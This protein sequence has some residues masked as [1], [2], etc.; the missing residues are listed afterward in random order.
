MNHRDPPPGCRPAGTSGS[1]GIRDEA[2]FR[3]S[4]R[5]MP[6]RSVSTRSF[7]NANRYDFRLRIDPQVWILSRLAANHSVD[8]RYTNRLRLARRNF[9]TKKAD[10]NTCDE[11]QDIHYPELGE[12]LHMHLN[13]STQTHQRCT[14]YF[15]SPFIAPRL[16]RTR[17]LIVSNHLYR[18]QYPPLYSPVSREIQRWKNPISSGFSS[19]GRLVKIIEA[20]W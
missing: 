16:A 2:Y 5:G 10:H 19:P 11:Q 3:S 8:R 1:L 9:G 6:H 13:P 7:R 20:V 15:S 12:S 18:C 17:I 14:V 4:D